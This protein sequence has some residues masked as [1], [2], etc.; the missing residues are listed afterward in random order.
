LEQCHAESAEETES[1]ASRVHGGIHHLRHPLDH[2]LAVPDLGLHW[3]DVIS[4]TR[5]Q[6]GDRTVKLRPFGTSSVSEVGLGCWQ[7]GGDQWGDVSDHDS[8]EVLRASVAKGVTFLDTADVYGAGR[9]E[10]LIGR[11]LK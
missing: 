5:Y 9:S 8:L 2:C 1:A 10:E 3:P 7:I 11:F 6:I 4:T